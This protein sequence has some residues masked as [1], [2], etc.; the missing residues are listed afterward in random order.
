MGNGNQCLHIAA[1]NGHMNLLKFLVEQK[2]DVNVQNG[3]GQT[4]LHMSI[5]YDFY[6][7]SKYLLEAGANPKL[8]NTD[9]HEALIG[10]E[11]TRVGNLAWDNPVTILKAAKDDKAELD[12]GLDMLEKADVSTIDKGALAQTGM[13]K[14]KA[15]KNNWDAQRFMEI[16]RK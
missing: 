6:F 2:A 12:Y 13:T 7:Q 16:M 1:Q 3:K 4:P 10:I 14:K 9:G 8:T 15:C 5:E 11:G